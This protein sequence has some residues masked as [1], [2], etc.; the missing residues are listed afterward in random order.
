ML[1]HVSHAS[2]TW[3]EPAD[4]LETM[5]QSIT[6]NERTMRKRLYWS[7][8]V[9]TLVLALALNRKPSVPK[10]K[11]DLPGMY[12][13]YARLERMLIDIHFSGR[14]RVRL[15]A[16]CP[17]RSSCRERASDY[18]DTSLGTRAGMFQRDLPIVFRKS[19][20]ITCNGRD[21]VNEKDDS[22]LTR[23]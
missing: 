13:G 10:L 17:S 20:F 3:R 18:G 19:V 22:F 16:S 14:G 23:S 12:P 5:D 1:H 6:E 4:L 8:Y 21:D 11:V 2:L 7:H 15:M 9:W